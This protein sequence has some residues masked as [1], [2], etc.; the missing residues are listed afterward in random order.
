MTGAGRI[1]IL[2][3]H[4]D[5]EIVACGIAALRA[6]AAGAR[7]HVLYLTTGVPPRELL[8]RRHQA[9]YAR[10]IRRRRD[11]AVAAAALIGIEPAGFLD[12]PGRQ[13][14]HHLDEAAEAVVRAVALHRADALWVTA[15]EGGHQDHDAAN[16]LAARFRRQLA[17]S[18]FAA[19]NLAGGRVGANRFADVCGGEIAIAATPEEAAFKAQALRTYGSERLNLS[20]IGASREMYRPLPRHDYFWPPH[21]GRLFRERFHWVPF[22]HPRIDFV[23]SAEIYPPLA[24]WVSAAE[25]ADAA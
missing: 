1:L 6:Q 19:Y 13:L 17:V 25:A 2:A 16:A 3:P 12:W 23:P 7:L 8:W 4:P 10:R 11:E 18:E 15:F 24:R 5:D 22:R 14:R 9:D 20:H 21:R